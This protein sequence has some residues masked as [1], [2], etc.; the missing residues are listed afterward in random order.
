MQRLEQACSLYRTLLGREIDEAALSQVLMCGSPPSGFE[1]AL[2]LLSSAEFLG[3][4][5]ARAADVH[6]NLIHRARQIMVHRLL[7]PADTVIDLGGANAPLFSFGWSHP[8]RK[9]VLVD[10]PPD[11]RH[12]LYRDIV[13][14]SPQ[15]C[16]EVKIHYG[17][18]THLE[19]FEDESFDLVWSGQSIEHVDIEAG[20]RMVRAARRVLRPGGHFCL[21]TPNRALTEIHTRNVG[22][23]FIHPEHRH[24]YRAEELNAL[25]VDS[26]FEIVDRYGVCEMPR[27]RATGV[28]HYEDF[29]LGNTL[30]TDPEA[31]Y[32]LYFG[33]QRPAG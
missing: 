31:G 21:D 26:G 8:F 32:I 5:L 29:V 12:E 14:G 1:L 24:E 16:G 25:L 20:A 13:I 28:F 6:L 2:Q 22:G 4:L 9:M 33:C 3:K 15:G 19:G 17:D 30:T 23:G 27:S 11:E 18:M 10:L 7:P